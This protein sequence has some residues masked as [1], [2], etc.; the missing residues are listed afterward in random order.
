MGEKNKKPCKY[1]QTLVLYPPFFYPCNVIIFLAT[2]LV[3]S[4]FPK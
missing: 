3:T 4:V 2:E 1:V